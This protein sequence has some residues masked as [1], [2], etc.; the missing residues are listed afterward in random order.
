MPLA[1]FTV[2]ADQ[3]VPE[4]VARSRWSD[5]Q[6]HGVAISGA[7]ARAMEQAVRTRGRA[8]L[9]PA[10]YTVDL[11]RPA[12]MAPCTVSATIVREGPRLCLVDAVLE[13]QGR[14]V[15]RASA[16][17]LR[18][19]ESPTG[20]VWSPGTTVSP[21]P[22]EL[23]AVSDDPRV[24]L[25]GS[26]EAGW[27]GSFADH[28]NGSRKRT[29]QTA[30]PV[31]AGER[32][33]PFQAVASIADATSMVTNWGSN[34]VEFINTDISLA[35]ARL[36]VSLEVGLVALERAEHGGIA[37]GCAVVF[38]REGVLG[39]AMVSSL[40]NARRTV[41]FGEGFDASRSRGA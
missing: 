7:L 40:A 20:A 1:F 35:L 11:F 13:Q 34:G 25:F 22:L 41:N 12:S 16:I 33:S 18:P 19:G 6:M 26:D 24:P 8:E 9:R 28:Q 37:A 2:L 27:T 10:R 39:T 31:V 36:P 14:P 29:W 30:V 4:E 38:D 3:L 21:P 15:A 17:F 5:D 23:A 32:P